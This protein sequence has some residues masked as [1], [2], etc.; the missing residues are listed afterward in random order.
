MSVILLDIGNV[1]VNVDFLRFCRAVSRSGEEGARQ[2]FCRYCA[3][4]TKN[5]FDKGLIA[6]SDYLDMIAG[7]SESVAMPAGQLRV[8][9]QDI[10]TPVPQSAEAILRMRDK[11]TIW[12]M[13]DTDPLHFT[14]LLN[15][16]QAL[17]EA[18]R[19]WLSFEHG[20]LKR[21]P[22]SFR[23]VLACSGMDAGECILIDDR[24]DNCRCA[25]SAGIRSLLFRDWSRTLAWLD[26]R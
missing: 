3:S 14:F 4:E 6:P 22:E 26:L 9:W 24:P 17:K 2:L 1:I 7:D 10:F 19:Y 25:E 15:H 23:A 12:I 20:Y 5:R 18:E 13:S 8:A 11:H 16:C 21:E